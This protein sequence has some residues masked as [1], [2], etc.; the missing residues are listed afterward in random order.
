MDNLED[1]YRGGNETTDLGIDFHSPISWNEFLWYLI[2]LPDR[3]PTA[4]DRVILHVTHRDQVVDMLDTQ[5]VE[6]IRHKCLVSRIF[7]PGYTL[8]VVKV[9]CGG[10][11]SSLTSIVHHVLDHLAERP[12]F[13][14]E[15]YYDSYATSLGAFDSFANPKDEIW[16]A[17]TN[18]R[19]KDIRAGARVVWAAGDFSVGILEFGRV[20]HDVDGHTPD[21][22]EESLD[23]RPS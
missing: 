16:S 22:R 9:L 13:L 5:K 18:V 1:M 7:Y 21:G 19:T 15:V 3:N 12:S 10:I 8:G 17:S 4:N 14:L 2:P 20:T 6:Y 23:I 11:T